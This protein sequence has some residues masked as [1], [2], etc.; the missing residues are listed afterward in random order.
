MTDDASKN[1]DKLEK[2]L[3]GERLRA[4][5]RDKDISVP[6]VAEKLRLDEY[7]VRALERNEFDTLG[8]PV[9]A[10]GHL[11]KYAEL[12]GVDIDD[13]MIDYYQM[14]RAAGAPPIVGPKRKIPRDINPMPWVGG[15]VVVILLAAIVYWWFVM[16]SPATVVTAEPAGLLPFVAEETDEV[17]A[18]ALPDAEAI[19]PAPATPVVETVA[20]S[21]AS[22]APM[23]VVQDMADAP[24]GHT[25]TPDATQ[26]ALD[27]AFTGDCWA[28][29]SDAGGHRL[30]YGLG[31]EGRIVSLAGDAPLGV[32]LGDTQNVSLTVDGESWP[33]P[34]STIRGRV[35]RLTIASTQ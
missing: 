29:V 15:G 35:A 28:E 30:Y 19:E 10:K 26:I 14:N 23:P 16:R 27:L 25:L 32:I 17:R 31:Q 7:K 3:G 18:D 20:D 22:E 5:R 1:E 21:E 6:D 24:A 13:I 2:L 4:A 9:F 11:R 8:A 33:I 12:V 34:R